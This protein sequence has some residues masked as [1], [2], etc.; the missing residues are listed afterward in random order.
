M[1]GSMKAGVQTRTTRDRAMDR[2]QAFQADT[3]LARRAF[4]G[5][6]AG[7]TV[8][9]L[10][11]G[12]ALAQRQPAKAR[13]RVDIS[14]MTIVNSLGGLDDPYGPLPPELERDPRM[15]ISP[16][17]IRAGLQSGLTAMNTSLNADDF[18]GCV[19]D[20]GRYD[21]LVRNN[22][23]TLSKVWTTQDIR[24]AKAKNR[25]GVIY[26]VQNTN[27]LGDKADRVDIFADLGLRIIQLTYNSL[28]RV[29]G[30]SLA[31]GNPGLTPFG[32][33]VVERLNAR[34]IVVD[35]SHSGQRI[36]L[37]AAR[38]SKQ[39]I[40]ITHTGCKSLADSPR[41]KTDEELR[42]V[43]ERGGYIGIYWVMFLARQKGREADI[44]DVVAHIEHALKICGEDHVGIGTDYGITALNPN[45]AIQAAPW[46]KMVSERIKAGI[47]APGEDP[48]ILPYARG[49]TGP[50]QFQ[51]LAD[52]LAARGHPIR[53]I[54]KILGANFVRYLGDIWGA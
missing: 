21:A 47:A 23:A 28:N 30:G 40:A 5:G 45:R 29:G 31:P 49:L 52:A 54:E 26:G 24:D 33:E 51:A 41:S 18:E 46:V 48:D 3:A 36:C 16:V 2:E 53:R 43:A 19:T 15:V 20:I 13:G 42:L 34:R 27:M 38:F 35:L 8:A 22:P 37:D 44:D 1:F 10:S 14:R 17:G 11:S 50:G 32:R 6:V 4:M 39:P 25:I 7:V 9:A 12:S